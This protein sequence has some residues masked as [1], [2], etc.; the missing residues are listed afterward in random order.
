MSAIL[1]PVLRQRFLDSNAEPLAGGLLY[2]YVAGTSTPAAT[3]ADQTG[4]TPNT[5]P[6]VLDANGEANV[7]LGSGFYKFILEDVNNVVQW[8]VD[9]VSAD[10]SGGGGLTSPWLKHSVTDGQAATDLT[11]E[12]VDFAL[13]TSANYE[14]EIIRG[15]TVIANGPLAIQNLNGS[16]RVSTGLYLTHESHGVTFT[17]SQTGMVAQLR[18]ALSAGPGDGTIKLRR[19]L[20]AI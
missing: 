6:I 17:V 2:S 7:W 1:L 4:S 11:S 20:V 3:Y 5:N 19:E 8:T 15:T 18:A 12:T 10:G 13:Y 16:G 14:V 9:E